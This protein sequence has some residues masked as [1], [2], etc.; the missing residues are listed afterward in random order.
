MSDTD[1]EKLLGAT[2]HQIAIARETAKDLIAN[3]SMV[4]RRERKV[5]KDKIIIKLEPYVF[6]FS[7]DDRFSHLDTK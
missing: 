5:R 3:N 2:T 6:D 4:K 7:I 1:L